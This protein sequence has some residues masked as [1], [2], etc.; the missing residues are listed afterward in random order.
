MKAATRDL[1]SIGFCIEPLLGVKYERR[2]PV[3]WAIAELAQKLNKH[4]LWR[5]PPNV[6]YS[7]K[8]R[9]KQTRLRTLMK[10]TNS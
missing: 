6:Q 5:S 1:P 10:F 7:P 9:E 4:P 8:N 3:Q 2:L